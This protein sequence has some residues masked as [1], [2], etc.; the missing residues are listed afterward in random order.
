M[1]KVVLSTF[2]IFLIALLIT[3]FYSNKEL[4]NKKVIHYYKN[5]YVY[6][7]IPK[8]TY[9]LVEKKEQI[10]CIKAPCEPINLKSYNVKYKKDYK[11]IIKDLLK[12]KNEV[13]IT[14]NDILEKENKV[15][16]DI[17]KE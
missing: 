10:M 13:I 17:I 6:D 8:N 16:I 14:P 9:I 2:F 5:N 11:K 12:D 15:L 1:K 7:I 4:K 3:T